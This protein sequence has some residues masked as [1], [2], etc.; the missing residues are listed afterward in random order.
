[1]AFNETMAAALKEP[2][3][4]ASALARAMK[5][6]AGPDATLAAKDAALRTPGLTPS[7]FTLLIRLCDGSDRR[8][9][10]LFP[11]HATL[12]RKTGLSRATVIR[13]MVRLEAL[14]WVSREE[15]RRQDGTRSTVMMTVHAPKLAEAPPRVLPLMTPIAGDKVAPCNTDRVA[16][17]DENPPEQGGA[18]Q[19]RIPVSRILSLLEATTAEGVENSMSPDEIAAGLRELARNMGGIPRVR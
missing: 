13:C 5:A 4:T 8:T 1:M 17:C 3:L 11:S 16:P 2:A 7:E 14:G 12:A 9:G 6:V 15:R 19:Q 18:M 10:K